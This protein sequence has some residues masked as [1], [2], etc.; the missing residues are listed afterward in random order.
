MVLIAG[1][2]GKFMTKK[3]QNHPRRMQLGLIVLGTT[4]VA[5]TFVSLQVYMS[6]KVLVPIV[7]PLGVFGNYTRLALGKS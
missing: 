1:V 2:L 4:T 7:F 6:L 5:Y 3:L